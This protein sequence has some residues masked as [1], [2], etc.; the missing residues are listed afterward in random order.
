MNKTPPP[1]PAAPRRPVLAVDVVL[2]ALRPGG[3]GVRLQ[4]RRAEPYAGAWALPGVALRLDETLEEAAHRAL[5]GRGGLA[6]DLLPQV[7]LEQL[8]T[9]DGLYRDPRGRTVSVAHLALTRADVPDTPE[10]RWCE[11][12]RRGRLPFDHDAIVAAA[13]DRLRGK[14]RYTNIAGQLI[15]QPFAVEALRA[16]Y[17][18]V[19]DRPLNRSNF[20]EK[21]VRIG[22]I[23]RVGVAEAPPSARGGRPAHLYRFVQQEVAAEE[24][25]FV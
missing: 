1:L 13:V 10:A 19:L 15:D 20:R 7:Y 12:A 9:F 22:L 18:A 2:L 4:R 16:V 24:R 5:C 21:L 17:E 25:E 11:V 23:E 14:L 8:C 3:L 6:A